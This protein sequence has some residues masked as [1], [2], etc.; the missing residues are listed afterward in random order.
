MVAFKS[1]ATVQQ[2]DNALGDQKPQARSLM[3]LAKLR[4]VAAKRLSQAIF[5]VGT[6]ADAAI[7]NRDE[8]RVVT[9]S[10]RRQGDVPAKSKPASVVR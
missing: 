7:F 5:G 4:Y 9:T 8:H 1:Q 3:T 2:A 10:M 6:H